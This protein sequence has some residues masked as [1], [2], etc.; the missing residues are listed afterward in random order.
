[1][2][3]DLYFSL[4]AK[5]QALS[6]QLAEDAKRRRPYT[7]LRESIVRFTYSCLLGNHIFGD[8]DARGRGNSFLHLALEYLLPGLL[9]AP[10]EA[11]A[12]ALRWF[13]L[14]ENGRVAPHPEAADYAFDVLGIVEKIVRDHAGAAGW[15][16][17]EPN[18][19][20]SVYFQYIADTESLFESIKLGVSWS[21]IRKM[22]GLDAR[23]MLIECLRRWVI[24]YRAWPERGSEFLE[25]CL[26]EL[27]GDGLMLWLLHDPNNLVSHPES[28]ALGYDAAAALKEIHD[29]LA[30]ASLQEDPGHEAFLRE[31]IAFNLFEKRILPA[32]NAI[33]KGD[34]SQRMAL[35]RLLKGGAQ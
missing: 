34:E 13:T 12:A 33:R 27:S 7:D 11:E 8:S 21:D 2:R 24:A 4:L 14:D 5:R 20:Q 32:Y 1:M 6:T 22:D 19:R 25:N 23:R 17:V 29:L 35:A 9:K 18:I 3:E 10:V 26:R 28:V 30:A 15:L 31:R 16:Q